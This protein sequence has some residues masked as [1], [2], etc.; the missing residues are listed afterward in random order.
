MIENEREMALNKSPV[1]DGKCIFCPH[2]NVL[3]W[4]FTGCRPLRGPNSAM[5]LNSHPGANV[6]IMPL[7]VI[8]CKFER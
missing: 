1:I 8:L 3:M 4:G 5:L 6:T 2:T 7:V